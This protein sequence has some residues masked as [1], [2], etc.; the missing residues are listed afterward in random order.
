[1]KNK[2]L[3]LLLS[4]STNACSKQANTDR[5]L[6]MILPLLASFE[7]VLAG[8]EVKKEQ[9]WW[10]W[11]EE[12]KIHKRALELGCLWKDVDFSQ[13]CCCIFLHVHRHENQTVR[14]W[15]VLIEAVFDL[16]LQ[17]WRCPAP[18]HTRSQVWLSASSPIIPTFFFFLRTATSYETKRKCTWYPGWSSSPSLKG[19]VSMPR[20]VLWQRWF[21]KISWCLRDCFPPLRT[22]ADRP[23]Q[24]DLHV[25]WPSWR[26][27]PKSGKSLVLEAS[28][29]APW[30]S[31]RG[32][33]VNIL[34]A[35]LQQSSVFRAPKDNVICR[36][37]GY[38][39]LLFFCNGIRV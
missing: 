34:R 5:L 37:A 1:M 3:F 9:Q 32:E 24:K 16:L 31:S 7:D 36:T 2:L 30:R 35:R 33:S 6:P 22:R 38:T 15:K 19:A 10:W 14:T 13:G 18:G 27:E 21:P 4:S 12:H 26:E 29:L 11:G 25:M 23:A 20:I 17:R 28:S 8:E 39:V